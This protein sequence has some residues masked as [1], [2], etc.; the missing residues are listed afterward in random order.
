[1]NQEV[2][3][4]ILSKCNFQKNGWGVVGGGGGVVRVVERG[5]QGKVVRG[6]YIKKRGEEEKGGKKP[7]L[8]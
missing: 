5:R 1:M 7:F 6:V 8:F 2:G 3:G 4:S